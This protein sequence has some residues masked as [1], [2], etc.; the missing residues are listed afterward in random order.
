MTN[1][2]STLSYYTLVFSTLASVNT[3]HCLP[4]RGCDVCDSPALNFENLPRSEQFR[5]PE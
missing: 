4:R 1:L 2:V 5:T 3:R